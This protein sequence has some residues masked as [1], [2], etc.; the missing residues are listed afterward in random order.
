VVTRPERGWFHWQAQQAERSEKVIEEQQQE[1]AGG[2]RDVDRAVVAVLVRL[3][4]VVFAVV[5]VLEGL[6]RSGHWKSRSRKGSEA[7][8][9]QT[10]RT[11]WA[12]RPEDADG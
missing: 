2:S 5:V 9:E 11:R 8:G 10:W 12:T 7:E 4:L 1:L 6:V 3:L